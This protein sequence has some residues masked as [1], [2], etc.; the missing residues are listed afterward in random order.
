V[1]GPH[2]VIR[3]INPQQGDTLLLAQ[4]QLVAF[5]MKLG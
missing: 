1:W 4:I 3:R 5:F 2:L